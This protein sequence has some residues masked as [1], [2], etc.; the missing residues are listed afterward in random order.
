M[1]N[2]PT[3][4]YLECIVC[5]EHWSEQQTATRCLKCMGPLD[6]VH[7]YDYIRARLNTYSLKT[8]PLSALKYLD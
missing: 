7:D 8:S 3:H 6:V 2:N 5:G 1:K 4:Y